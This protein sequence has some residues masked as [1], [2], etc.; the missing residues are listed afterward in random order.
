MGGSADAG[1]SDELFRF[2]AAYSLVI[3]AVG[4]AAISVPLVLAWGFDVVVSGTVRSAVV[5]ASLGVMVLTYVAERRARSADSGRGPDGHEREY[6]LRTRALVAAAVLG[7]G[8]GV[9][10]AIE[11]N[12]LVGG[13][14]FVGAYL[15]TRM[16]FG[17]EGNEGAIE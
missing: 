6:S 8:L 12:L 16:A 15:F 4:V 10:A 17:N 13:V 7:L 5:V 3:Y 1:W 2:L 14:F 11:V 9:Y